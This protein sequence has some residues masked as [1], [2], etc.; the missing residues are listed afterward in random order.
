MVMCVS[1]VVD[2]YIWSG[3]KI[4]SILK[5]KTFKSLSRELIKCLMAIT[6]FSLGCTQAEALKQH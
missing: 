5:K 3:F 4:C 1:F 2:L 6:I